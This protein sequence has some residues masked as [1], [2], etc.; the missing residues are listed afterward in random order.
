M[1]DHVHYRDLEQTIGDMSF[2]KDTENLD[3]FRKAMDRQ[4]GGLHYKD[5]QIQPIEF[6]TKNNLGYCEGNVIKY[7]SR[8]RS[9]NGKEDLLKAIHYL[10]L[11][12]EKEY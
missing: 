12:I 7:V 4:E 5:M 6:I 9:K 11:L 8:H 2:V 3:K 1:N 10:E